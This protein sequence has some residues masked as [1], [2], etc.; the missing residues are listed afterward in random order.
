[1]VR[2]NSAIY[3]V[4]HFSKIF[5]DRYILNDINFTIK[6]GEIFGIIGTSGS[7]KSTLL[8]SL[9]G[10]IKADKG[11]IKFKNVNMLNTKDA[12]SF[13][14]IY[15]HQKEL[16][17]LYGFATQN[18]SFYPNLSVLENLYYFGTLY[19]LSKEAIKSNV[20]YLLD[21]VGLTQSQHVLA[22]ELSGGMQRRLDIAC[23]LI[24]DPKLLLLD[25]PTADL[26]PVLSNKI[27]NLLRIINQ[28]GTTIILASHHIIE[29]DRLCDKVAI[30]KDGRI[31]AIGKPE[32]IKSKNLPK[33]SIHIRSAPGDYKKIIRKLKKSCS[34]A[35]KNYEIK[36]K[37]LVIH[38]H[39]LG[40]IVPHAIRIINEL[41]EKVIS[42]ESIKPKLD[43][44]FILINEES[45]IKEKIGERKSRKRS[46]KKATI[47]KKKKKSKKMIK[48]ISEKKEIEDKQSDKLTQKQIE[49]IESKIIESK[50]RFKK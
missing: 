6:Q 4:E 29:L 48:I 50:K 37:F 14:S 12:E 35:I 7:G 1:M 22:K 24:H 8:N 46:K 25:E 21:L 10:F 5:G 43:Q 18:P 33:E 39:K 38:S 15:K 26:D 20:N 32:E 23:S 16:K 11:D 30:L 17:K 34:K 45:I 42:I 49:L 47:K 3:K 9:I 13:R 19:N 41:E 28:R 31:K 44:A 40:E 2:R 27:W 36:N